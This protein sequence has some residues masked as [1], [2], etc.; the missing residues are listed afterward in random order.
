[1]SSTDDVDFATVRAGCLRD[2]I[3]QSDKQWLYSSGAIAFRSERYKIHVST[4]DRSSNPDTRR[5][6]PIAW[7]DPPLLFDLSEDLGEQHDISAD[8]PEIVEQLIKEMAAF[9]R[10]DE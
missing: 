9:R 8:H 7:H 5:R 4:K 10:E 1:M 6:E 2:L 3:L